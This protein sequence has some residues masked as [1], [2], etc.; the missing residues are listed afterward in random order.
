M[1]L[2][3]QLYV[4]AFVFRNFRWEINEY[5]TL[6]IILEIVVA[7]EHK[8]ATVSTMAVGSILIWGNI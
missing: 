1:Y 3:L 4:P 7:Q 8:R 2:Y 6:Q 5:L